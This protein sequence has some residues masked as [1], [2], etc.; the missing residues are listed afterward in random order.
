MEEKKLQ[1]D[2]EIY[3]SLPIEYLMRNQ[4]LAEVMFQKRKGA[5]SVGFNCSN[6]QRRI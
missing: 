4:A 3:V 1:S 6:V 5:S 2:R